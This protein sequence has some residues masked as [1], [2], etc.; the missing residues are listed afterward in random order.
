MK[1]LNIKA[2]NLAM[3]LFILILSISCSKD[4]DLLAEYVVADSQEARLTGNLFINDSYV[5]AGKDILVLDVLANDVITNPDKVKIVDTSQ[6]ENGSV[7]INEDKTLTYIPDSVNEKPESNNEGNV[8]ID[9]EKP[10]EPEQTIEEE[11]EE[12]EEEVVEKSSDSFTYT[13]ETELEDGSKETNE[14]SVIISQNFEELK[15]FPTA[16]GFGKN[17]TGGR[18]GSVIHVTNLNNSGAGSLREAI[19]SHGIRTV[20]FDVAGTIN[21][22]SPLSIGSVNYADNVALENVTIAGETAPSPGITI[23]GAGINIY[24]SN[25]IFRYIT[26]R[27]ADGEKDTAGAED[28]LRVKNWGVSGYALKDVIIDHVT[29]THA[30]DENFNIDGKNLTSNVERV[31][32]QNSML[33]LSD[34][35]YNILIG[36]YVHEYSFIGNY[37]HESKGRNPYIGYGVSKETGEFINN[38]VYGDMGGLIV[39]G[40]IFDL[41]GNIYKGFSSSN[42][43]AYPTIT[44]GANAINNPDGEESDGALFVG[45]NVFINPPSNGSY[46]SNVTTY[47]KPSRVIVNSLKTS[48][49]I[50][51][52]NIEDRVFVDSGG[53]GNSIHRESLDQSHIDNYFQNDGSFTIPSVPSKTSTSRGASYDTDNDGIADSWETNID[54]TVG[55]KDNN[56]DHDGDGYTNLEEFLHFLAQN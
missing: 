29:L 51:Q 43:F 32:F 48:W 17:A 55:I 33:G 25:V 35:D 46:A 50:T 42:A 30:S 14:T 20:V 18:G 53:V 5:L 1:I 26:I 9:Q 7:T 4:T 52:S 23:T 12:E 37:L 22:T 10:Q 39:Y 27:V 41:I 19:K 44:Y 3:L 24:T 21:I 45:D 54:G 28:C 11:E 47:A 15:A 49:E 40:N 36:S 6:P 8:E 38:I 56:G 34:N 31:T 2:I 13:T 16:E